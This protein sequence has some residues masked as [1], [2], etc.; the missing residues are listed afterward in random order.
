ME[1]ELKRSGAAKVVEAKPETPSDDE[2]KK[3]S[4]DEK[5]TTEA[6]AMSNLAEM[7]PGPRWVSSLSASNFNAGRCYISFDGHRSNDDE[8][9]LFVT[10]DYGKSWKSIRGNLPTSAGSVRVL[11]EDPIS[12]NLLFLGCEF[13]A[14]VS[15]DRGGSWS[16]LAGLPTVAVHEFAFHPTSGE[17]V[18]GT[19]GR[20]I[21]IG[22]VSG[23]RQF[24]EDN[25]AKDAVLYKPNNVI[26]W[27]R[28]AERGSSGTRKFTGT[29][30]SSSAAL[31]YSLGKSAR[32]VQL[33]I[34]D[35][36]GDIIREFDELETKKG[37]HTVDWDLR[38]SSGNQGARRGGG[39]RR[40]FGGPAVSSGTYLV[41]LKVDGQTFKET[42]EIISDPTAA[43]DALPMDEELEFWMELGEGD[44]D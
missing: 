6:K 7:M 18:V 25:V 8:P 13:G 34:T 9:Y 23:L 30:R 39:S 20:A 1:F 40:G 33:M 37:L 24:N 16:R 19:H 29:N 17:V 42:M 10:E 35:V 26:R 15:V 21:W 12:E 44:D 41:T 43:A 32:E 4:D 3:S 22:D 28:G 38:R 14:W 11:R 36:K 27:R 31:Q 2:A 5:E